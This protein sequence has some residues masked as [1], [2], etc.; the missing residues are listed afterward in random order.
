MEPQKNLIEPT[1]KSHRILFTVITIL[2]TAGVIGGSVYYILNKQNK[3]QQKQIESLTK[4]TEE[5]KNKETEKVESKAEEKKTETVAKAETKY[6]SKKYGVSFEYGSS[7]SVV[8]DQKMNPSAG[9]F[10]VDSDSNIVVQNTSQNQYIVINIGDLYG[11]G[12][13]CVARAVSYKGEVIN[14]LLSIT[15]ETDTYSTAEQDPDGYCGGTK[16]S[17]YEIGVTGLEYKGVKYFIRMG[18]V[19][20]NTNRY[21][22]EVDNFEKIVSTIKFD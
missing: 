12:G 20:D 10:I 9:K 15:K 17:G 11:R 2:L 5:Q 21:Q 18:G 3:E 6:V 7:W 19:G 1:K 14:K 16:L 13:P 22:D 4:K 8:E